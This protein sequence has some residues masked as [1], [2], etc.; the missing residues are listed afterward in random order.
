MPSQGQSGGLLCAKLSR[1]PEKLGTSLEQRVARENPK[2]SRDR[3][4]IVEGGEKVKCKEGEGVRDK[5]QTAIDD[6]SASR[7]LALAER[8]RSLN[9][10]FGPV[11]GGIAKCR[12]PYCPR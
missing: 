8:Q 6:T 11:G 9:F 3:A 5:F 12:L 1:E 7:N 4:V 10:S 2:A